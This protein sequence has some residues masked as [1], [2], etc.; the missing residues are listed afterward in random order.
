MQEQ[1]L[2]KINT[3]GM[4][5]I[6]WAYEGEEVEFDDD[7]PYQS[8]GVSDAYGQTITIAAKEDPNVEGFTF[9]K[10]TKDGADF[11]TDAEI[12]VFVDGDAE[13]VAVF[14]FE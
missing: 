2:V 7:Y 5:Q 4:G 1:A 14:E 13:Y 3:E 10:W 11:S 9:V 6:A 12:Q 8:A